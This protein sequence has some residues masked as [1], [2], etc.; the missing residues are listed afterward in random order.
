MEE[1]YLNKSNESSPDVPF[2]NFDNHKKSDLYEFWLLEYHSV[3]S[4]FTR[5][6]GLYF[7]VFVVYLCI[8]GT[9][10]FTIAISDRYMSPDDIIR[11]SLVLFAIVCSL[12][13]FFC[14]VVA[15]TI[16]QKLGERKKKALGKLTIEDDVDDEFS[17]GNATSLVFFIFNLF[18]IGLFLYLLFHKF[19]Y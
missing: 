18:V 12:L 7:L 8:Q 10:F 16:V 17:I 4:Q 11:T 3:I 19:S 15:S 14:I 1:F 13:F 5:Y 6:V 9:L 2:Q